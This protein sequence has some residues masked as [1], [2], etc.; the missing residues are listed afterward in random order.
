MLF[1]RGVWDVA[2]V[3]EQHTSWGSFVLSPVGSMIL[4]IVVLLATGL[5]VSSMIGESILLTSIRKEKKLIEKS[6]QEIEED[7]RSENQEKD[8]LQKIGEDI[9]EIKEKI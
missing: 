5:L 9:E 8:I 7:L 3:L 4:G 1:W 6:R 2:D